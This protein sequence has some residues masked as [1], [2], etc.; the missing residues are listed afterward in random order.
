MAELPDHRVPTATSRQAI[1]LL[2]NEFGGRAQVPVVEI[3]PLLGMAPKRALALARK[4]KL[5]F[6]AYRLGTQRSPWLVHVTDLARYSE[7]KR[8]LAAK[9]WFEKLPEPKIS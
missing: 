1:E 3:A 8:D 4:N 7:F 5:P 6:P 9:E 2:Q